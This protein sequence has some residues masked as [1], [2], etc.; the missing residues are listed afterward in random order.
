MYGHIEM[1]SH[2]YVTR[3]SHLYS[4]SFYTNLSSSF[5]YK[6]QGVEKRNLFGSPPR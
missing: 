2:S 4:S 5:F 6:W 3:F 1:T